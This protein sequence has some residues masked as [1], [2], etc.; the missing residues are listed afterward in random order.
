MLTDAASACDEFAP[1][2]A[3]ATAAPFVDLKFDGERE[4][5]RPRN[6]FPDVSLNACSESMDCANALRKIG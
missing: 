2:V 5:E 3:P 4:R 6:G 1:V